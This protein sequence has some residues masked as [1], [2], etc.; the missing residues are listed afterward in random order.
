MRARSLS[1]VALLV[2]VAGTAQ[3]QEQ[4]IPKELALALISNGGS[5]GGEILVGQLPPDLAAIFT[6]PA[7]ARVL[8]SFVGVSFAQSI[9]AIPGRT[10]SVA[11]IA[12]LALTQHGWIPREERGRRMGGLQYGPR[13]TQP[14]IYCKVDSPDAIFIGTQFHGP[15]TLL[16]LTR[17]A[18]TAACDP[19]LIA[20]SGRASSG[21]LVAL[22]STD[23]QAMPDIPLSTVP[24]LYAP[25]DFRAAQRC[26]P[27][28]IGPG[29]EEQQEV[30][31]SELSL[32][33]ILTHYGRQLDSAGWKQGTK[34]L[35]SLSGMWSDPKTGQE[36]TLT[37]APMPERAGCYQVSLRATRKRS[38]R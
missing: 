11:A 12:R 37:I 15:T 29:A 17:N 26:Y 6:P 22:S 9:I 24:P 5:E 38:G 23:V 21:A 30:V 27:Q 13:N 10:D 4:Q 7:G 31:Q 28:G 8:G 16:R 3:A 19:S 1:L 33:E 35:P 25:G 2:F 36:V 14:T 32:P 20:S 34:S 18:G